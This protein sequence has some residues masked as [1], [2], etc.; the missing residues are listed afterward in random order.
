MATAARETSR[1]R[2]GSGAVEFAL[3]MPIL[4]TLLFA[5]VELGYIFYQFSSINNALRVA[6]RR[7]AIGES[8][9]AMQRIVSV[10]SP[11]RATGTNAITVTVWGNGP[12]P[13]GSLLRTPLADNTQRPGQ[14]RLR[15]TARYEL[16]FLTFLQGRLGNSITIA[17]F[18]EIAIE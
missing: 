7:G 3:V 14:G 18:A 11:W 5:V 6:V 2:R 10:M 8:N 9:A 1:R 16:Q 13:P 12:N 17:P 4:I 15:L